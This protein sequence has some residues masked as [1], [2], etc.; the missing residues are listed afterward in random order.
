MGGSLRYL[1]ALKRGCFSNSLLI[2]SFTTTFEKRVKKGTI[3]PIR[4]YTNKKL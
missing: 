2:L 4:D 3:V 1:K